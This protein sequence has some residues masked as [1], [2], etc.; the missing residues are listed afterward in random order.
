MFLELEFLRGGS[1]RALFGPLCVVVSGVVCA[2]VQAYASTPK[3]LP[4][5]KLTNTFAHAYTLNDAVGEGYP[6]ALK[7]TVW[8]LYNDWDVVP[9]FF[10]FRGLMPG[11]ATP[12]LQS[13]QGGLLRVQYDVEL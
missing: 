11:W 3:L 1:A 12:T 6:T 5:H 7:A 10:E 2:C 9:A 13:R 4:H 8:V